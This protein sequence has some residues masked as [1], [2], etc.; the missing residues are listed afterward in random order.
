M[1][2]WPVNQV[3]LSSRV[4]HT[5]QHCSAVCPLGDVLEGR[6]VYVAAAVGVV[7]VSHDS[8]LIREANCTLWIIE[9]QSINEIDGEFDDYKTEVLEKLEEAERT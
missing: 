7:L 5:P 4:V 6:P 2:V 1:W 3:A 8:R 9:E